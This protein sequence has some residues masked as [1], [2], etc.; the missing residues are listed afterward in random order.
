MDDIYVSLN[1]QHLDCAPLNYIY[2]K[3]INI[4]MKLYYIIINTSIRIAIIN[5]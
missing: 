2:D 4:N 3:N 5:H 1:F